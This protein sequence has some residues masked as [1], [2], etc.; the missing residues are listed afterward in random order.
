M[1]RI[2]LAILLCLAVTSVATELPPGGR[3]P[4][5]KKPSDTRPLFMSS[6]KPADLPPELAG[7]YGERPMLGSVADTF[8]LGEWDFDDGTSQGWLTEDRTAQNDTFFHITDFSTLSGGTFG[9]LIPLEGDKSLWC[10]KEPV[11]QSPFC[12]W[13]VLPGYGHDWDQRFESQTFSGDTVTISYKIFW[14]VE[15][16]YDY[17]YCQYLDGS[18]WI[19][20]PVDDG[21]GIYGWGDYGIGNRI[22]SFAVVPQGGSTRFRF[23]FVSDGDWDDEDG[24]W[25]TDGALIIDSLTVTEITGLQSSTPMIVGAPAGWSGAGTR[26]AVSGDHVFV[27]KGMGGVQSVDVSDPENPVL[28]G[29]YDT[30]GTAYDIAIDGDYAYVADGTTLQVLDISDPDNPSY[31][32]YSS[33]FMGIAVNGRGIAVLGDRA[34][35]A[36]SLGIELFNISDPEHPSYAGIIYG[37]TDATDV[38]IAGSRAYIAGGSSNMYILDLTN[39]A[40]PTLM[41][42]IYW[43]GTA[44]SVAVSGNYAY[45]AAGYQG[46]AVIDVSDPWAPTLAA[47]YDT[48]GQ[49]TFIGIRGDSAYVADGPEGLCIVD[50][51]D[52]L[53]PAA[54]AT[55]AMPSSAAGIASAG[56][57]TY[58]VAKYDGPQSVKFVEGT[59]RTVYFE[60]FE[61]ETE[62]MLET[63]DGLWQASVAP[64]FGNY[65]ALHTG[66]S[67]L[68]EDPCQQNDTYLWGF[69]DDPASTDYSCGGHP[70]QG[71]M[72]YGPD[73]TGYYLDNILISPLIPLTDSGSSVKLLFSIY[74]DLPLDNLQFYYWMVR[75][76]DGGCLTRWEPSGFFF[77]GDEKA[78]VPAS[79]EIGNNIEPDAVMIQVAVGV[80]D[81]CNPWCG[82]FGTGT[83][84]SHAPLIDDISV[85]RVDCNGPVFSVRDIDLFQDNFPADGTTTGTA[86]ADMAQD[87]LGP[88]YSGIHPGDSI[89]ITVSDAEYGLGSYEYRAAVYAYVRRNGNEN[90]CFDLEDP[91]SRFGLGTRFPIFGFDGE[92]CIFEMDTV[93]TD[94]SYTVPVR[95]R[96]CFDLNDDV[97]VPGDTISYFFGAKN[98]NDEWAYSSR[99]MDGQ[100]SIFTTDDIEEAKMS[101]FEFCIL[102]VPGHDIL[103]VDG[104]DDR[105]GPAQA[106][107]DAAFEEIGV[108]GRVDRYDVL[109]P[110]SN[111]GNSLASRVVSI[112]QLS[113]YDVI[114]WS[115]G[116]LRTGLIGDGPGSPGKA[117]DYALLK[118]FLERDKASGIYLTGDNIAEEWESLVTPDAAS[119][120]SLF[121]NFDL[122]SGD[123]RSVG[124][125]ES[126]RLQACGE[127]FD[128]SLPPDSVV[129]FG[130]CPGINDF[131]VLEET[132]SSQ[133]EM[134]NPAGEK[135]YILSQ[136]TVND[137]DSLAGVILSG[138]SFHDLR[139]DFEQFSAGQQARH[140]QQILEWLLAEDLGEIE[141]P[142]YQCA[143]VAFVGTDYPVSDVDVYA[144]HA[145]LVGG[146]LSTV[147]ISD[148]YSPTLLGSELTCY[149][150]AYEIECSGG[151]AYLAGYPAFQMMGLYCDFWGLNVPCCLCHSG[152]WD[153][154]VPVAYDLDI[155]DDHVYLAA[156]DDG[157]FIM[158][159][160]DLHTS[161]ECSSMGG[162]NGYCCTV[163]SI[164]ACDA[165]NARGVAVSGDYAFIVDGVGLKIVDVSDPSSPAI[166]LAVPMPGQIPDCIRIKDHYAYVGGLDITVFDISEPDDPEAM[167][168]IGF[169]EMPDS[170]NDIVFDQNVA[171]IAAGSAVV[172]LD[173][174][175]PGEPFIRDCCALE[176]VTATGIAVD[177]GYA[178]VSYDSVGTGTSGG[179]L[180]VMGMQHNYIT[181]SD[182]PAPRLSS[183]LSQNFPNPFN[184]ATTIQ[185]GVEK[186]GPVSLKIYDVSGRLVRTLVNSTMEA[187]DYRIVWDGRGEGGKN[188]ASGVYFAR[189]ET[190]GFAKTKKLVLLR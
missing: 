96:F 145:Y 17:G 97:L 176:N 67:V 175:E 161:F 84:H 94:D 148:P 187:G 21:E 27:A 81:M 146:Y 186:K 5:G 157:L 40:A 113:G 135:R 118:G 6:P 182:D 156:G 59:A 114:I 167:Q 152:Q 133:A 178:Y 55:L 142:C 106:Y 100:G 124:Q 47:G 83:C 180:L 134:M 35:V 75:S 159:H 170:P 24:L 61:D 129:A 105:G 60:D 15:P 139:D 115:S 44:Y 78:W 136:R 70:E 9:N 38:T 56:E 91:E 39:P 181:D 92:Y 121:M 143:I 26:I 147:D 50:I 149:L 76:F 77:Y 103:Y 188:V 155:V 164:G 1:K 163:D 109:G 16:G 119:F 169:C 57:Y 99:S 22:E 52:P 153:E 14:D 179:G 34:Y 104:T 165:D 13:E 95:G 49:A 31:A 150:G 140:M 132:G 108:A 33:L 62:G 131:D 117:L 190:P 36:H 160:E 184:P 51:S 23:R 25:N 158:Y 29:T 138:F 48:D 7:T 32:G 71:A 8:L 93:F 171:F 120:R 107:F 137:E 177:G 18:D 85:I 162:V 19:D 116:D 189:I 89:V 90:G 144:D 87:L 82:Y 42:N 20:L 37:P 72:P 65:A 111:T 80:I 154:S 58:V 123:H 172:V 79:F 43:P 126:P 2:L 68:Q 98:A 130:G 45:M 4:A 102:P 46:M 128:S 66:G 122:E 74:R 112:D 183:Y 73:E 53:N 151:L 174:T 173:I 101:P 11:S 127:V 3:L 86:R 185:Y 168:P 88:N 10:G 41:G 30:P 28:R 166:T 12:D 64:P 141:S 54:A 69:F 63:D 125:P 110:S